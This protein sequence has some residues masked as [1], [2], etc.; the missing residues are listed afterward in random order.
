MKKNQTN[1]P[2]RANGNAFGTK[3]KDTAKSPK[4]FTTG[5]DDKVYLES[6]NLS[7]NPHENFDSVHLSQSVFLKDSDGEGL[8][9]RSSG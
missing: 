8:P 1:K 4:F 5:L 6:L 9:W 7:F 2:K 3:Y